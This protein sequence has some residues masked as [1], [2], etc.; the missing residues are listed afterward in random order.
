VRPHGP[1]RSADDGLRIEILGCAR[2]F[3]NDA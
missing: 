2:V 1:D 3:A